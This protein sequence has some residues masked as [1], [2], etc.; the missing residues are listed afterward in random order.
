MREASRGSG[1]NSKLSIY[2]S[3]FL[4]FFLGVIKHPQ[5]QSRSESV[6]DSRRK[7]WCVQ[8]NDPLSSSWRWRVSRCIFMLVSHWMLLTQASV[9]SRLGRAEQLCVTAECIPTV[10]MCDHVLVRKGRRSEPSKGEFCWAKQRRINIQ[11]PEVFIGEFEQFWG[12]RVCH[13]F[14]WLKTIIWSK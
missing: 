12:T 1:R 11:V 7:I 10:N 14:V 5:I 4:I 9:S 8:R 13:T 2:L 6:E 3:I